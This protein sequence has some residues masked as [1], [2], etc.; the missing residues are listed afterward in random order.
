MPITSDFWAPIEAKLQQR[1]DDAQDL[2]RQ[3]RAGYQTLIQDPNSSDGIKNWA[4]GEWQKSLHP[5]ARK[6]FGKMQP[7]V[8]KIMGF[9]GQAG[10]EGDGPVPAPTGPVFDTEAANERTLDLAQKKSDI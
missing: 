3:Q 8:Q 5:E 6:T 2:A 4:W 9:L 7:V 1:H 10:K